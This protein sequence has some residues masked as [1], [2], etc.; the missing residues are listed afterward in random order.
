ML[1]Q[2][3]DNRSV[4]ELFSE[5]SREFSTLVRDEVNL[6][7]AEMTQKATEAGKNIAFM[8]AGGI[9]ALA[10][11]MKLLDAAIAALAAA[12]MPV[13]AAALIVGLVV[14]AIAGALV[15]KGLNSLKNQDMAPRQTI[16][17]LKEDAEWAKR[18]MT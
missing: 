14:M 7:K 2:T 6:A 4:G 18:Q 3:Q 10:G 16:E 5:L 12:G 11:L 1:Q 17:T 8:A 15:M 9:L 13:W